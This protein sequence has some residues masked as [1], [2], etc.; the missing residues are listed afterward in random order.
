MRML[1]PSEDRHLRV[2]G[3]PYDR[4]GDST[5]GTLDILRSRPR[6]SEDSYLLATAQRFWAGSL[7]LPWDSKPSA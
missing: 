3:Y 5:G 6:S 7:S 4:C 1:R 2:T